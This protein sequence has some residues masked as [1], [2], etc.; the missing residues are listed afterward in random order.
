MRQVVLEEFEQA[1]AG[2]NV[3][4][5]RHLQVEYGDVRFVKSRAPDGGGQVVGGDDVV[6]FTQ[7]PIELLSDRRIVVDDQNAALH[8][9]ASPTF[10]AERCARRVPK[11]R[12]RLEASN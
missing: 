10:T 9:W 12:K 1:H 11:I 8:Y 3:F 6:L 5:G 2:G 4:L 7:R